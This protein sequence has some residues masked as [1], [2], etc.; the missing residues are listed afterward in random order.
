MLV[1]YCLDKEVRVGGSGECSGTLY[2]Y[3]WYQCESLIGM[4]PVDCQYLEFPT[5]TPVE[6]PEVCLFSRIIII[7]RMS[8]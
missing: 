4:S 5:G 6:R 1:V 2:S 7:Y 3:H 8:Q